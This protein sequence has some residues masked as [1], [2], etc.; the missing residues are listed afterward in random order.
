MRESRAVSD[1]IAAEILAANNSTKNWIDF[2]TNKFGHAARIDSI[3]DSDENIVYR[4][5]R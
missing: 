1:Q 5:E 2:Q 3:K 4:V